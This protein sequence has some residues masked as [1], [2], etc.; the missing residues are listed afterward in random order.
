MTYL[1]GL[2]S[3]GG[4]VVSKD[5]TG[6]DIMVRAS[7]Q[8]EKNFAYNCFKAAKDQKDLIAMIVGKLIPALLI[9]QQT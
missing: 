4:R 2:S 1:T 6:K 5:E 3:G 8:D 9:K 7:D